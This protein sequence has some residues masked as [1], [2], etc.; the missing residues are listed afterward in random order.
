[1]ALTLLKQDPVLLLSLQFLLYSVNWDI[2][3]K[4][5]T[6]SQS[7]EETS[8]QPGISTINVLLTNMAG[9]QK[10]NVISS[11]I[12]FWILSFCFLNS[13]FSYLVIWRKSI[14]TEIICDCWASLDTPTI[15][16]VLYKLP[17][18]IYVCVRVYTLPYTRGEP[19]PENNVIKS[20]GVITA[21]GTATE[22]LIQHLPPVWQ[23]GQWGRGT[24]LPNLCE[25]WA[26]F[27]LLSPRRV[28]HSTPPA[29][30]PQG[31]GNAITA[32]IM[33]LSC[34]EH[35]LSHIPS[36]P[37]VPLP[38]TAHSVSAFPGATKGHQHV[39]HQLLV[40]GNKYW[41]KGSLLH[42]NDLQKV[43]SLQT[44]NIRNKKAWQSAV[45]N[46]KILTDGASILSFSLQ[47]HSPPLRFF[48]HLVVQ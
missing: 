8:T 25:S 44:R 20:A 47:E 39:H 23:T 6:C 3:G 48:P 19:V 18:H 10:G 26:E 21:P 30:T 7:M 45:A 2:W 35:M 28:L 46:K 1:M 12:F 9:Y 31:V 42:L 37:Q 14:F 33:Q 34:W 38:L 11:G 40:F 29:T 43:T 41:L 4:S 32:G 22:L 36:I 24:L 15:Y 27:L 17:L 5:S 16:Y 13:V